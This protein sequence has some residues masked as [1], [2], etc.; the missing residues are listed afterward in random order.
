[1]PIDFEAIVAPFRQPMTERVKTIAR[2]FQLAGKAIKTRLKSLELIEAA[3]RGIPRF[4]FNNN[5]ITAFIAFP[6]W[7]RLVPWVNNPDRPSERVPQP[8]PP[9]EGRRFAVAG[10]A[11]L[12]GI[13]LLPDLVSSEFAMRR[14]LGSL[15]GMID[16]IV[17]SFD[18]YRSASSLFTRRAPTASDLIGQAGL[19]FRATYSG[20]SQ[21]LAWAQ[22]GTRLRDAFTALGS[23]EPESP[24]SGPPLSGPLRWVAGFVVLI[25]VATNFLGRLVSDAFLAA[26]IM[27]LE[28]L[29]GLERRVMNFRRR[30]LEFFSVTMMELLVDG[31]D[32]MQAAALYL[33]PLLEFYLKFA[34]R[35]VS[36]FTSM[37]FTYL[38]KLSQYLA[39]VTAIIE[40]IR[41]YFEAKDRLE[42][43]QRM[44][45][46]L[47]PRV[48]S[49]P[50]FPGDETAIPGAFGSFPDIA[51]ELFPAGGPQIG[52]RLMHFSDAAGVEL[53]ALGDAAGRRM[54]TLATQLTQEGRRLALQGT[55]RRMEAVGRGTERILAS[56]FDGFVV[57]ATPHDAM[58]EAFDRAIAST[59]FELL[60]A[61]IPLYIRGLGDF[62]QRAS[63]ADVASP[64][65]TSPHILA[66][67]AGLR[68]VRAPRI[69]LRANGHT[70][71]ESLARQVAVSF[72]EQVRS[73]YSTALVR[74]AAL[75]AGA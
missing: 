30:I 3:T 71:D 8:A 47:V 54:E 72:R 6:Q 69:T 4:E 52:D 5:A 45:T 12:D 21:I 27:I 10:Q 7:R 17:D 67:R 66:R 36:R 33:I 55:R 35:W 39:R 29:M 63:E 61:A 42:R 9:G 20:S 64:A 25:P 62:W 73:A 26:R 68:R 58:G 22:A 51:A 59:G 50:L 60:G 23:D 41:L 38:T 40:G 16:G 57:G 15:S 19:A 31:W 34:V 13:L 46:P 53:A 18:R 1:M 48:P 44:L 56:L 32:M 70:L 24:S 65:P 43:I 49:V 11:F 75:P 14:L 28:T 74:A 2:A 37:L